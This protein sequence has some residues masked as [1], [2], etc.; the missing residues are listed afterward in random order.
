MSS[1]MIV[2]S[3]NSSSLNHNYDGFIYLSDLLIQ[4]SATTDASVN[5]SSTSP[6][7]RYPIASTP[8][9]V[10]V[11]PIVTGGSI[12]NVGVKSGTISSNSCTLNISSSTDTQLFWYSIGP[13]PPA[14]VYASIVNSGSL[15]YLNAVAMNASGQHQYCC[16]GNSGGTINVNSTYGYGAWQQTKSVSTPSSYFSGIATDSSGQYVAA[17][18]YFGFI[19]VS[20]DYGA[21]WTQ[22]SISMFWSSITCNSTGTYFYAVISGSPDIYYSSDSGNTWNSVT[23]PASSNSVWASVKCDSTG[24]YVYAVVNNGGIYKSTSYGST[25][26]STS[27]QSKAWISIACNSTG[28][29]VV[30]C[31]NATSNGG[32]WISN[33]SG[34]TWNQTTAPTTEPWSSISS[35]S[36]GQYLT[37]VVNGGGQGIWYSKDYGNTWTKTSSKNNV[38]FVGNAMNAN[39]NVATAVAYTTSGSSVYVSLS[40]SL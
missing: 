24:E 12:P 8:F 23:T 16:G 7:L 10:Y 5:I 40:A 13:V 37:A 30:A 38:S 35:N 1:V 2:P 3:L 21:N 14:P 25:W 28:T 29:Q 11:T 33:D 39:G 20:S 26:S 15:L 6:T 4:F 31:V 22:K 27:A 34:G 32:I 17:C 18:V 9:A 36:T 19:Y